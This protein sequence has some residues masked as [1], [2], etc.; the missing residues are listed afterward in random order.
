MK[1]KF[2]GTVEKVWKDNQTKHW[3]LKVKSKGK[4]VMTYSDL[5]KEP[6]Y[7]KGDK[8]YAGENILYKDEIK[9]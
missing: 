4:I 2:A 7:S 6:D 5:A 8:V 1:I 3:A 9:K